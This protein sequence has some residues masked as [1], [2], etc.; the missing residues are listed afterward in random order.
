MWCLDLQLEKLDVADGFLEHGDQVTEATEK[1]VER[2]ASETA[3]HDLRE[4]RRRAN[5][6][7]ARAAARDG[8]SLRECG[9]VRP[10]AD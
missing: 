10:R 8:A 7:H 4:Q 1:T 3:A 2:N 6:T 5:W 9:A